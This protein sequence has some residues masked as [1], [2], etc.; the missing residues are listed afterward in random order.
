MC[1]RRLWVLLQPTG[2]SKPTPRVTDIPKDYTQ[3]AHPC[4]QGYLTA[5]IAPNENHHARNASRELPWVP[6][7]TQRATLHHCACE[8]HAVLPCGGLGGGEVASSSSGLG[9]VGLL[10]P[11]ELG[12]A[13]EEHRQELLD[14]AKE[15][16]R[17]QQALHGCQ[18]G[19]STV[20]SLHAIY[21]SRL[22]T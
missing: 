3:T 10:M 18:G 8:P 19:P 21:T 13:V 17:F 6:Y 5:S 14:A 2:R 9:D 12:V 4:N 20:R 16:V 15:T 7:I 22:Y 11:Q 1:S